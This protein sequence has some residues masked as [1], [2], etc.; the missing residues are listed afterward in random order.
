MA[1]PGIRVAR[2]AGLAAGVALAVAVIV[3]SLPASG[4]SAVGADVIVYANQTGELAAS[5]AGPKAF[6]DD[7]A[8][9][10]G[11]SASGSF[12]IANQ[13]G[14]TESI[15]LSALP[16]VPDL[17]D[18]LELGLRNA[19]RTLRTGTIGELAKPGGVA[20]VLGPG[21]ST[22]VDATAHLE[23]AAGTGAAAAL[24]EVAIHFDARPVR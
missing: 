23:P 8:M 7:A 6:I 12:R 4:A 9:H 21:E 2:L 10:P 19:G 20:L 17:N 1:A 15:R 16:S 18:T 13:T 22:T 14:V 5:P 11:Q 24:V 3:A